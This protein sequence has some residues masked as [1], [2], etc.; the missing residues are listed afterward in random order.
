MATA[1]SSLGLEEILTRVRAYNPE[2]DTELLARAYRFAE[3]AHAGQWRKSGEPYF[4]HPVAVVEILLGLE[5]DVPTLCAAL[6]HD[7]V[8]DTET[9]LVELREGFGEE[10]TALVDGVTKVELLAEATAA[11]RRATNLG[12]IIE[13]M[14]G[15]IRVALVK[16]AD[17]LH[18]M[19]TLG[20]MRPA[21][22]ARIAAETRDIYLPIAI[23]LGLGEIYPELAELSYAVL[24]REEYEE[25]RAIFDYAH[26]RV[27]ARGEIFAAEVREALAGRFPG[28]TV[29]YRPCL[30][31][32]VARIHRSLGE[33]LERVAHILRVTVVPER[34]EECYP[35]LG[36]LHRLRQPVLGRFKDY[37]ATPR[38]NQYRALHTRLRGRRGCTIR[39][40]ILSREMDLVARRGVTHRW[41]YK[42][43]AAERPADFARRMHWLRE[44]QECQR[45]MLTSDDFLEM[46]RDTLAADRIHPVTPR[47]DVLDLPRGA[48]VLDFACAIHTDLAYHC[49]GGRVDG[50]TV[51]RD[52]VLESGN[53]VEVVTDPKVVPDPSWLPHARTPRARHLLR[54][55]LRAAKRER[56]LALGRDRLRAA[57]RLQGLD[58][59]KLLARPEVEAATRRLGLA[60]ATHLLHRLG[61]GRLAV[62]HL[63]EAVREE[64]PAAVPEGPGTL[65]LGE[66]NTT[67]YHLAHCC[68]PLAG[69]DVIGFLSR[70]NGVIVHRRGCHHA[71]RRAVDADA[72]VPVR[73]Q[74]DAALG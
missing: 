28:A 60:D 48:T 23:G 40:R 69:D 73:W 66:A 31:H 3:R 29:R 65:V 63:L 50:R 36:I 21:K 20:A 10:V 55:W 41:A 39:A 27:R 62:R 56:A 44:L 26:E 68:R 16:V 9:S 72:M 7:T 33:P 15:D 38:S 17:R 4:T 6:L 30:A 8:E 61:T 54:D 70:R 5:L 19:R 59:E 67:L 49:A 58:D 51:G 43:G 32:E 64:L 74:R 11:E 42:R 71:L 13:A 14:V 18:N 57:L 37:I 24:H 34:D 35:I 2:A 52:H 45:A 25:I 47:G 46:A 22:Q 1:T 53:Q 12:K